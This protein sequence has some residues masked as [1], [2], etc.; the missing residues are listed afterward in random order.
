MRGKE[1]K[2]TAVFEGIFFTF[3]LFILFLLLVSF[4]FGAHLLERE[5]GEAR[6]RG[7][8]TSEGR[9]REREA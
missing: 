7:D 6:G 1:I 9:R 3:L 5:K 4:F 8:D 2:S